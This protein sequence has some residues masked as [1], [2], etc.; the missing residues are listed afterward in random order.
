MLVPTLLLATLTHS[1]LLLGPLVY[2]GRSLEVQSSQQEEQESILQ[3]L[4]CSTCL[5]VVSAAVWCA[6]GKMR[7]FGGTLADVYGRKT[8][9]ILSLLWSLVASS[10]GC[11]AQIPSLFWVLVAASCSSTRG[12]LHTIVAEQPQDVSRN[13]TLVLG[14][15][16]WGFL[17][18]PLLAG[19]LADLE[20]ERYPSYAL[21]SGMAVLLCLVSAVLVYCFVPETL[22]HARP[23]HN[24]PFDLLQYLVGTTDDKLPKTRYSIRYSIQSKL[25]PSDLFAGVVLEEDKVDDA[26]TA[27]APTQTQPEEHPRSCKQRGT[28]RK[29]G[30]HCIRRLVDGVASLAVVALDEGLPVYCILLLSVP[31]TT[32]A[33]DLDEPTTVA[34][35]SR[36]LLSLALVTA[37]YRVVALPYVTRVTVAWNRALP[38]HQRAKLN[39]LG[40][41]GGSVDGITF[42][43]LFVTL[44][45]FSKWM[46]APTASFL[47]PVL[48]L[49]CGGTALC[50]C[51]VLR[52]ADR[53]VK[54]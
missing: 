22:P 5:L 10:L 12:L 50:T 13:M 17:V 23:V 1:Y 40:T 8:V 49:L 24:M 36:V 7:S 28:L 48:A 18:S 25:L 15:W 2:A 14:V 41:A 42:M 4:H 43:G 16:G 32:A 20:I 44:S 31:K 3:S 6:A 52:D 51:A 26:T 47:W 35:S 37:L 46:V 39:C 11:C 27:P 38:V 45:C 21:P 29:Y 9:L 19:L 33:G 53:A 34:L 54:K 30:D